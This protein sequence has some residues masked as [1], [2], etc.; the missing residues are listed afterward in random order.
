MRSARHGCRSGFTVLELLVVLVLLAV[1]VM[2]ALPAL[3]R[4]VV[5][6]HL[7]SMTLQCSMF[8]RQARAEAIARNAPAVVV[9]DDE[10]ATIVAFIDIHNAAGDPDPDFLFNPLEGMPH[11][12]TDY[13]IGAYRLPTRIAFGGP[14]SDPAPVVGFTDRGAG[15]R[16]VFRPDGSVVD[17]GAVRLRDPRGN[18][19]EVQVAPAA[20][21]R[22]SLRKWHRDDEIWYRRGTMTRDE[23]AGPTWE[24]Y[25]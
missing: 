18:V 16:L 5:R 7:Q 22:V 10:A 9:F 21:G 24:W 1:L 11:R 17:L 2:V 14:P 4:M 12:Q 25:M 13:Q 15:P 6:S 20:T 3:H 8:L 19:F 23:G